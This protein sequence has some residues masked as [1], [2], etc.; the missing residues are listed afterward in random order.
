VTLLQPQRGRPHVDRLH[1][2]I[3]GTAGRTGG[4]VD[5]GYA[6]AA[7]EPI[8]DEEAEAVGGE[9]RSV[10]DLPREARPDRRH[11]EDAPDRAPAA[12]DIEA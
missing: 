10:G 12:D 5:T 2:R 9:P 4:R 7:H 8:A 11:D 1:S 6:V 3:P